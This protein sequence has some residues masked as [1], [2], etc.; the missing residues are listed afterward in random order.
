MNREEEEKIIISAFDKLDPEERDVLSRMIHRGYGMDKLAFLKR[1]VENFDSDSAVDN[2][3][4]NVMSEIGGH[5]GRA[6]CTEIDRL[7]EQGEKAIDGKEA[8]NVA[9]DSIR[10]VTDNIEKS[11]ERMHGGVH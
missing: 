3:V 1:F 9:I 2:I 10:K 5:V 7:K 8:L 4:L 11:K 6:L